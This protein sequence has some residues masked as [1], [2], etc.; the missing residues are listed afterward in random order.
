MPETDSKIVEGTFPKRSETLLA[1]TTKYAMAS[2]E[3]LSV[4][5]EC[6][7]VGYLISNGFNMWERNHLLGAHLLWRRNQ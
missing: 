4:C 3:H 5:G 6:I 2:F 7:S 1:L